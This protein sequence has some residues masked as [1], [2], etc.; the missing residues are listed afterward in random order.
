VTT[1]L[2]I[3]FEGIDGAGKS[4][5][6]DYAAS[7]LR[8]QKKDIVQTREPGGTPF[9]EKLRD[10]ILKAKQ[11]LESDTEVLL[12]FA[13]RNEHIARVIRP[14]LY[15]GS[16]VICDRFTDATFAYQGG[17]SGVSS[18]RIETLETWV[19]GNLQPDLTFFF[20]LPILAAQRRLGKRKKDR[21]ESETMNFHERV[22]Q[23]YLTRA[24]QYPGRIKII[25][26]SRNKSQI[27]E[28]VQ[29]ELDRLCN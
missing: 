18:S 15:C 24:T 4:T 5:Q 17:G 14:A 26:S 28:M 12:M 19:Q 3:T 23:G 22:R 29:I 10:M 6:L 1:G 27:R 13:A 20:D 21:F 16:I 7:Y 25:D 11:P 2:F 9:S 8:N